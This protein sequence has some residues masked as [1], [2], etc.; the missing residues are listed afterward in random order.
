MPNRYLC[1]VL[2][3]MRKCLETNNFSYLGGLIEEAQ[4]MGSRMESAIQDISDIDHYR[5]Q[6]SAL[7]KEVSELRKEKRALNPDE[8]SRSDET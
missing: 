8:K 4:S 6:R 3:E 7:R 2:E 1:E 5:Q